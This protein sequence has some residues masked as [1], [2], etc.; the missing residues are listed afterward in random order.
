[1]RSPSR[2]PSLRRK[3]WTSLRYVLPVAACAVAVAACGSA[4]SPDAAPLVSTSPAAKASLT[5]VVM[6]SPGAK[7]ER[8]TLR[9]DPTGGTHPGA[10]AACKQLLAAKHPFAPIPRGIMCPMIAAGPQQ[11]R[12]TGTWFGQHI[13]ATFSRMNGCNA[14]RWSQLGDVFTPIP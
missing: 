1:M 8:W 4:P 10:A 9:C 13:D 14:V 5:V 6:P 2:H 11:A 7:P 3:A 12:I